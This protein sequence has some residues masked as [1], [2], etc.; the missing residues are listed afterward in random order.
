MGRITRP[1]LPLLYR[2]PRVRQFALRDVAARGRALSPG[3][4]LQ[5]TDDMLGCTIAEDLLATEEY[6]PFLDP[7]P[8]PITIA[9]CERD[10]IFPERRYSVWA[11]ERVPGARYAVLPR[12]GHVPMLDDPLLVADTAR[13]SLG[14]GAMKTSALD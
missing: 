4:A 5:L 8:C 10:R 14:A 3:E 12:V 6:F 9:W 7:A 1:A 13:E 2:N 11:K